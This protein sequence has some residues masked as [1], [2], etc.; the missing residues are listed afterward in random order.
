MAARKQYF[1]S[2]LALGL[3]YPKNTDQN[4]MSAAL[5]FDEMTHQSLLFAVIVV[6]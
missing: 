4:I 6:A 5:R 1:S 2:S 3:R